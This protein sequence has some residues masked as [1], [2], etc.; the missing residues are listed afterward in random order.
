[1]NKRGKR[2]I[3]VVA[4]AVMTVA[5][6]VSAYASNNKIYV[7]QN[8]FD[9]AKIATDPAYK[10]AFKAAFLKTDPS[11]IFV[12]YEGAG[13]ANY[14]NLVSAKITAKSQGKLLSFSQYA[15]DPT[16]TDA[17]KIPAWTYEYGTTPVVASNITAVSS[18]IDSQTKTFTV[19]FDTAV[20]ADILAGRKL[21]LNS[22]STSV[23][24]T[25]DSLD[26]TGKVATFKIDNAFWAGLK[27]GTYTISA[28][29]DDAWVKVTGTLS[30]S[31]DTTPPTVN[32][33]GTNY[34]VTG[35]VYAA[36][37]A[38]VVNET[39]S[40]NLAKV[41]EGSD[42]NPAGYNAVSSNLNSVTTEIENGIL[43]I[44]SVAVGNSTVTVTAKDLTGNVSKPAVFTINVLQSRPQTDQEKLAA[45]T[46]LISIP[47][48]FAADKI[49]MQLPT[50]GQFG[51]TITWG[52]GD[53][54]ILTIDATGKITNITQP[55]PLTA[56]ASI[57]VTANLDNNG[58]KGTQTF[59]VTVPQK[60]ATASAD[61]A[62]APFDILKSIKII[63]VRTT[64]IPG[65]T[66]FRVEGSTEVQTIDSKELVPDQDGSGIIIVTNDN[67]V[68]IDFLDASGNLIAK[69]NLDVSANHTEADV[70][71]ITK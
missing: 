63:K 3:S 14:K 48:I 69:G 15:K 46:Q 26:S 12:Y 35:S 33:D 23:T 8:W 39:Y 41:F 11:Q 52:S 67:V 55:A 16:N 53:S 25:F 60:Q 43:N 36:T 17:T 71:A 68:V 13:T 29:T 70:T 6:S 42:I 20:T 9:T 57:I 62:V 5:S 45:D 22:G 54:N 51:S 10:T 7:G 44:K 34:G 38:S 24:A 4:V 50:L 58:T 66:Q 59:T 61:V 37:Y 28:P 27:D 40:I 47:N 19:T 21:V 2:V 18:T 30:A 65:A 31:L 64:N 56:D 32:F 1:M 49:G